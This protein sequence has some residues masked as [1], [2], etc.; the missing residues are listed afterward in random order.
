[1]VDFP[2]WGENYA[3]WEKKQEK[4]LSRNVYAKEKFPAG[5]PS[6]AVNPATC[7]VLYRCTLLCCKSCARISVLGINMIQR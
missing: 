2:N 5:A 7:A 4:T 3:A 1:L 6:G